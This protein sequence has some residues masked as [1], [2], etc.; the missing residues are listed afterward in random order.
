M[1]SDEMNLIPVIAPGVVGR[2]VEPED[3]IDREA[4]I[5]LPLR[6][7]VKILNDVGARIWSMVDGQRSVA[8]IA[9]IIQQEYL[10]ESGQAQ[11]DTL[12]FL[13]DLEKRDVL[14]MKSRQD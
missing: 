11:A 1:P 6:G 12:E 8:D 7:Q 3:D 10:V 9:G 5:L 14:V 4:V 13:R 2:I